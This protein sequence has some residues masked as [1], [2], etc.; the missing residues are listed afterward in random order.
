MKVLGLSYNYHDASAAIVID[1]QLIFSA[2][3][4]RYSRIKH[5]PGFP[6]GAAEACLREAG[7][8]AE[9]I[10]LIAFHEEPIN[11]LSRTVASSLSE[12]PKSLASFQ[13]SGSD[14]VKSGFRIHQ[15]ISEYFS[16]DPKKVIFVPHHLSHA[17]LAF[18][19][20]PFD[21]AAI[22]TVDAVGEWTCSGI[23]SGKRSSSHFEIV[24]LDIAPYP[25]SLGLF[26]SA[27]TSFLGFEVNSGECST[28]ALAAFGKPRFLDAMKQ[29]L[30]IL[31]DGS[32]E[33]DPSFFKFKNDS[34]LPFQ[35]KFFEIF[36]N[37]R[38]F[39]VSWSFDSLSSMDQRNSIKLEDE[40]YADI[41]A[42]AQALLNQ[43]VLAYANRTSRLTGASHLCYAGGVSLNCVANEFM[44]TQSDFTEVFIPSDP[45]DGGAAAG[46]ALYVH[47]VKDKRT[48]KIA[49]T[50]AIGERYSSELL[51]AVLPYLEPEKWKK[52]SLLPSRYQNFE[53]E[54]K[55][56]SSKDHLME[57]VSQEIFK[58]K[59][60]GWFQGRFESGPRALG[61]RSILIRPD[62]IELAR[63][64]SSFVKKRAAFRPYALSMTEASA[65]ANLELNKSES[66]PHGS[67][68]M[69]LSQ[70][71]ISSSIPSLRAGCHVDGS[72]RAQI[73][74]PM[75]F[76]ELNALLGAYGKLSNCEALVNTSF[77]EAGMP[78]VASPFDALLM[79]ARTDMDLLVIED[80]IIQKNSKTAQDKE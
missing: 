62:D 49:Q 35:N 43:A 48:P 10:D 2:A 61:G 42:S 34:S 8:K 50:A 58:G 4:E 47:A 27:I 53:L 14:A 41:A 51:T 36:G 56:M 13:L 24:P 57:L 18:L 44:R 28:M 65:R 19:T 52:F 32:H 22:M 60:I 78:L 67:R 25:H 46:A 31:P 1:G 74:R 6:A 33:L 23:F 39:N 54:W 71:V 66:F 17:A 12:W 26:Y 55:K 72:T 7:I 30:H 37:P 77:N 63:R 80:L 3:E 11:K 15:S 76:P 64:L 9:E 5:D 38:K 70:Q 29:V 69:Q 59:I 45:G 21:H 73:V 75:E 40:S 79:F 68:W 16:I 20:S